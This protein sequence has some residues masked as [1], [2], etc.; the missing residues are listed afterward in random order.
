MRKKVYGDCGTK[1][2]I[3]AAYTEKSEN[4]KYTK[5][6]QNHQKVSHYYGVWCGKMLLLRNVRD[7]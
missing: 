1:K 6:H 4:K 5:H 7:R 2:Y 3:C